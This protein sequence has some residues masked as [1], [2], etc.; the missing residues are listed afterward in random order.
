MNP[1]KIRDTVI[2]IVF[3]L[4][5][6]ILLLGNPVSALS[7][8]GISDVPVKNVHV[9]DISI[10]YREFGSGDPLILIMGYTGTMDL[11]DPVVLSNLSE[12]YRVIVFDNRGVGYSTDSQKEYT[13]PQCAEDTIGLMNALN[14]SQAH[15]LGWSMGAKIALEIAADHPERVKKLVLYAASPG[16]ENEISGD[17]AVIEQ[18]SNSS[19]TPQERGIR[20][21]S[22]ILPSQWINAHKDL[23][24]YLPDV[25]EK[26]T[27]SVITDQLHALT[28]W[29]G[30]Y[31][32][33][34]NISTPTLLIT[35]TAD[36]VTPSANSDSIAT[37]LENAHITTVAGGGHGLMYQFPERFSQTVLY[38]LKNY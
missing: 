15:I 9:G 23:Q 4:F 29:N 38:F 37:R 11:W 20:L 2:T 22:L 36:K 31:M 33:L 32:R 10:G 26:V 5:C 3:F 14:I 1:G 18:L 21:L 34:R 17:P 6:M 25:S 28:T 19:G 12:K 13:I 7:I 16:G 8:Q 35:G 27:P 30:V 24:S